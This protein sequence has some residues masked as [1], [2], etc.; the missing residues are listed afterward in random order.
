[1][2]GKHHVWPGPKAWTEGKAKVRAFLGL[3]EERKVE[4]QLDLG[5]FVQSAALAQWVMSG[6][7]WFPSISS[8]DRLGQREYLPWLVTIDWLIWWLGIWA[9]HLFFCT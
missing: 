5:D 9:W 4:E 3:L 8:W 7:L 6:G 2:M 1:M